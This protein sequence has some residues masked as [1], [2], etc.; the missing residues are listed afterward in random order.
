MSFGS[1]YKAIGGNKHL[2]IA[3]EAKLLPKAQAGKSC[4]SA[5]EEGYKG[6]ESCRACHRTRSRPCPNRNEQSSNSEYTESMHDT[7]SG[8]KARRTRLVECLIF[9]NQIPSN[10]VKELVSRLRSRTRSWRFSFQGTIST[11]KRGLL[12]I[13]TGVHFE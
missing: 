2:A 11:K 1:P 3:A 9:S 12:H 5:G 10:Q 4:E 7:D 8:R 13:P 6:C